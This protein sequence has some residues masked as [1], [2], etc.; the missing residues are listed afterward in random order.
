MAIAIIFQALFHVLKKILRSRFHIYI[1]HLNEMYYRHGS[2][3]EKTCLWAYADSKS[4]SDQGLLCPH[5][6]SLDTIECI[7]GEQ[8]AAQNLLIL[9]MFESTFLLHVIH[10]SHFVSER[11]LN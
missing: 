2:R 6:E 7:N 3:H 11:S 9:R 8:K 4:L 1:Y 5:I 10:M